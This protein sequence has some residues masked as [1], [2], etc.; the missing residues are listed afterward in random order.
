MFVYQRPWEPGGLRDAEAML[1]LQTA[2]ISVR[3]LGFIFLSTRILLTTIA[4]H[5][6][7]TNHLDYLH[8][9]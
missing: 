9:D 2:A 6:P 1:T 3:L 8:L 7:P 5:T 4:N